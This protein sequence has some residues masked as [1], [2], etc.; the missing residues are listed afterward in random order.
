M[1]KMTISVAAVAVFAG[2]VLADGTGTISTNGYS[3][4]SGGEFTITP[5]AG[6]NL[7]LTGLFSDLSSSTF[8]SFCMEHNE[9]FN[10]GGNYD[11][12]MNTEAVHGGTGGNGISL[13]LDPRTAFLYWNFRMGTLAGF[14]YADSVPGGRAASSGALQ[15]AIW[16]FQGGQVADPGNAFV[17]AANFA[18][19]NNLWSGIGDVR[20]LNVYYHD[21]NLSQDQLT[22]I[23][24]PGAAAL[25]GLGALAAKRRRR[26]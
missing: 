6:S 4:G 19:S 26:A 20:V 9:T 21:G 25:M 1:I 18:V 5:D 3:F 16:F 2:S 13:A 10:P 22:I 15:D 11:M 14:D 8:E 12:F 17:A 23:P 24:T 7:G